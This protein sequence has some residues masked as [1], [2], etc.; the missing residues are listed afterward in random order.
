MSFLK[1]IKNKYMTQTDETFSLEEYA[2]LLTDDPSVKRTPFERMIDAIGDPDVIDTSTTLRTSK[3]FS[4]R[5]IKK[6]KPFKEFHGMEEAIERIVSYFKYA[7]QG[8]EE[9]RQILYLLGPVGGGKSSLAERLKKLMAQEPIYVLTDAEGK[10]SPTFETPLGLFSPEDFPDIPERYLRYQLSPWAMKRLGEYNND[11]TKFRVTKTYPNEAKQ[12]A[13]SKTEPGDDNNQDISALVGK[14]NIRKLEHF[15]QNDPDSYSYSGGLNK[16]NQGLLEFVEMFKAPIKILHPLLTAT[17]E[18]D[19]NATEGLPS[20][21]FEGIILAHSNLSEWDAFKNDNKNEAFLDRV[22]IVKVPYCLRADEEAEIYQKLIASS[23]LGTKPIA[24]KTLNLLAQMMILTRL[25]PPENSAI[26][27]KLKVYNGESIKETDPKAKSLNDYKS[28]STKMEG[29]SGLSTRLA[30]KILSEVY[31]YD[32]TEI[33]ANP[34]HL[35]TVLEKVIYNE[36]L[37][38]SLERRYMSYLNDYIKIP[39]VDYIGKEIQECYLDSY[40]EYGQ[41]LFDRYITFAD[42]WLQDQDYRDPETGQLLDK[43]M[44]AE[45]LKKIEKPAEISNPKDFRNEV[46]NFC[47]HYRNDHGNYPDWGSYSKLKNVIEKTMFDKTEDLL[48]VIS[49]HGHKNKESA[50]KHQDFLVRMTDKGYTEKQVK[51]LCEWY[52]RSKKSL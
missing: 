1:N 29:F 39:Y 37:N 35:F 31:N 25:E 12:I 40:Y 49:F 51:L 33:A 46:V 50:K 38:E 24:P 14:T 7:A 13:L 4:N 10:L 20:I 17:Q 43:E 41:N 30:Y 3:I 52:V 28:E 6:Y 45:E 44:L 23:A 34:V 19:Y 15:D 11:L 48:P 8:L 32:T 47:L 26:W 22:Y 2:Q 9:S 42:Y 16:S 18:G 36:H 5:L 27:S 21:P